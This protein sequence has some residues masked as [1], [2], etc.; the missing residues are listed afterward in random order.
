MMTE[1]DHRHQ[2]TTDHHNGARTEITEAAACHPPQTA[3]AYLHH[4]QIFHVGL[5]YHHQVAAH[6]SLHP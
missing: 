6:H 5:T 2:T 4:Q 3:T 1:E